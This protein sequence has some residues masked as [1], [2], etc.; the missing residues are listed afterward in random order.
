MVVIES[1]SCHFSRKTNV[2]TEIL[3]EK[4]ARAMRSERN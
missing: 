4:E 3:Q 1:S 2:D